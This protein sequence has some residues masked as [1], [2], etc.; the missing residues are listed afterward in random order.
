MRMIIRFILTVLAVY[1]LL[2]A[3]L[4]VVYFGRIP[5]VEAVLSGRDVHAYGYYLAHLSHLFVRVAVL[6]LAAMAAAFGFNAWV[7][8]T[9][10]WRRFLPRFAFLVICT[11]LLLELTLR[12]LFALPGGS[13][14]DWLKADLLADPNADEAYWVLT[15]RLAGAVERD[16]VVPLRGWSQLRPDQENPLGLREETLRA[17]R[18]NEPKMYF[19]GDSFVQGM[20]FNEQSLPSLVGE[21]LPERSLVN[22]GVRGY[23]VDQ[24]Y[25]LAREIGLPPEGGE[26]WVGILTWDLDRAFLAFTHGQRPR[27]R[28]DETLVL[29]RSPGPQ[30]DQEYV[31]GYRMPFRSWLV[32]AVRHRWRMREGL[33]RGGPERDEKIEINRAIL[34]AWANWTREHGTP[35]RVILFHTRQDLAQESWRTRAV[36]AICQELGLP[37]FDTADVL[38]P[39]LKEK[40][41]WGEELFQP[42]DFHHTDLANRLIADGVAAWVAKAGKD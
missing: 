18:R 34:R 2:A 6:I 36:H 12:L 38:L 11:A 17:L 22:L 14:R 39:Y 21:R 23:G 1:G 10:G 25:L 41:T 19:F 13:R 37:L 8:A 35:M 15:A 9:G 4:A 27:Y 30:T 31:D 3:G 7:R 26:V 32:Q 28:L 5:G 24:M 16:H 29:E 42:G 40:G 33:E 20:P